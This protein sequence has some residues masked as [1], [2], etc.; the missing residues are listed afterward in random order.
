MMSESIEFYDGRLR[1][2][3]S[4]ADEWCVFLEAH[5]NARAFVAVQIAE[6]IEDAELWAVERAISKMGW[7]EIKAYENELRNG[8][9]DDDAGGYFIRCLSRLFGVKRP[10]RAASELYRSGMRAMVNKAAGCQL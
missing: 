5:P 9:Q 8:Q 10:L 6:A 1:P 4:N 3:G 2:V 7:P